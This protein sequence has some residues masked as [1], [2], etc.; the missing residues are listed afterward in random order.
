MIETI[1]FKGEKYPAFQAKGGASLFCRPFALEVCKGYGL[2]IGYGKEEWKFPDALG[3]DLND[4]SEFHALNLPDDNYDYIHSS[5]LLEHL[6]DWV[7]V[8]DYWISH[9]KVGGVLFLYLPHGDQLYWRPFENRKHVNWLTAEMIVEYLKSRD[10]VN[11][12]ST[13][14]H[15][16]NHSFTVMG[17]KG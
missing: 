15:D 11:I 17:V 13:T 4:N 16:L 7:G 1:N 9:L 14:G 12:F 10:F 8:L 2:D 5:H 6:P 3:V